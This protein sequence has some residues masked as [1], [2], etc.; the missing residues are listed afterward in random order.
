MK[1]QEV[2]DK[3][4]IIAANFIDVSNG[5]PKTAINLAC[6]HVIKNI[7]DNHVE[8][9]DKQE[10]VDVTVKAIKEFLIVK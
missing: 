9:K 3:S 10:F 4:K 2:Y 6:I 1:G 7:F 8:K 5:M